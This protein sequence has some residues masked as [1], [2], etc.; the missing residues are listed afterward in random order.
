MPS[1]PGAVVCVISRHFAPAKVYRRVSLVAGGFSMPHRLLCTGNEAELLQSRC[2][3]L[4]YAGYDAQA[5]TLPEAEILLRAGKC[6]LVIISAHLSE[7]ERGRI[8]SAAGKTATYVLRGLKLAPD[9]VAQVDRLL[10]RVN[11]TAPSER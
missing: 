9:L 1:V 2:A 10:L 3:V 11:H 5:A 8:I 4:R 7:W 6:E